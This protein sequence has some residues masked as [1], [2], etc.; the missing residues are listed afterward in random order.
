MIIRIS[1]ICLEKVTP[2]EDLDI[3]HFRFKKSITKLGNYNEEANHYSLREHL[4]TI[5]LYDSV[6]RN[7]LLKHE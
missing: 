1:Y 4:L 6:S 5:W 7:T 3:V 2:K